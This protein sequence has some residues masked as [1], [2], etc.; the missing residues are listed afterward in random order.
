MAD[1]DDAVDERTPL[2]RPRAARPAAAPGA[3]RAGV[4]PAVPLA[5][6]LAIALLHWRSRPYRA[7]SD[8]A[9]AA[10]LAEGPPARVA[11]ADALR[12]GLLPD[13][14]RRA[15]VANRSAGARWR[16]AAR[17]LTLFTARADRRPSYTEPVVATLATAPLD[18]PPFS[19]MTNHARYCLRLGCDYA[20]RTA[21]YAAYG[22]VYIMWHKI[23]LLRHL[24]ALGY[25]LVFWTDYDAVFT[26]C[27]TPLRAVLFGGLSDAH[28]SGFL[29]ESAL[30]SVVFAGDLSTALNAGA[31]AV[32]RTDFGDG[33]LRAAWEEWGSWPRCDGRAD[34]PRCVRGVS[35]HLCGQRNLRPSDQGALMRSL[36]AGLP[37]C[38]AALVRPCVSA[39]DCDAVVASLSVESRAHVR[40]LPQAAINAYPERT[41]YRSQRPGCEQYGGDCAARDASWQALARAIWKRGRFR[42]HAAGSTTRKAESM[43]LALRGVR[44]GWRRS[45]ELLCAAP[46]RADDYFAGE[47]LPPGIKARRRRDR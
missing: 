21:G 35:R 16:P 25:G 42:L 46:P 17:A 37:N 12:L 22:G 34:E 15:G 9:L 14:L 11:L 36:A 6:L 23:L 5:A 38:T 10:A 13:A 45:P 44:R 1:G 20:V 39:A 47:T 2:A 4:A 28:A 3:W 29:A 27:H 32:R 19:P 26:D 41:G 18:G 43:I 40:C 8:A 33:F 24:L 7:R 31:L 30:P